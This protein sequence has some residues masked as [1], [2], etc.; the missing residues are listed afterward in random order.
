MQIQIEAVP[1]EGDCQVLRDRLTAYNKLHADDDNFAPLSIFVRDEEG[2]IKG[3]LL[4][5][6]FWRWLHISIVWIDED[7]RDRGW[8]SKLIQTVEAEAISRGCIGVFV[9]S[10][11]FQAPDFYS[12]HGYSIWGELDG[13]PPGHR[14]IFFQKQLG[15]ED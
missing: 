4:G 2:H 9:D 10:L 1:E 11:S 6:T 5:E 7:V 3:G 12:K 13:L 8:G 15:G 14:R